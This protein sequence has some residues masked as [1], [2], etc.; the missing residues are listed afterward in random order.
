MRSSE[1]SFVGSFA[2]LLSKV[3]RELEYAVTNS[4]SDTRPWPKGVYRWENSNSNSED[5]GPARSEAGDGAYGLSVFVR[6]AGTRTKR[7]EKKRPPREI[8]IIF[9]H[10]LL[11]YLQ[12]PTI[13]D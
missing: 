6:R 10:V 8:A 2:C 13:L 4:P 3:L 9:L 11:L 5:D 7:R 1:F 12:S